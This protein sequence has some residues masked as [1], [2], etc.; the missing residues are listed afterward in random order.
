M[1]RCLGAILIFFISLSALPGC[2]IKTTN[3]APMIAS[4]LL[5]T[6]AL[7][8][9]GAEN[10]RPIFRPGIYTFCGEKGRLCEAQKP[11]SPYYYF[12]FR[13]NG[14]GHYIFNGESEPLFTF[15]WSVQGPSAKLITH[16]NHLVPA[17]LEAV[18]TYHRPGVY[19]IKQPKHYYFVYDQVL[20]KKQPSAQ[21]L[22][23][24]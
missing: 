19:V 6:G 16:G 8:Y 18:F 23:Q 24:R 11:G 10:P 4:D 22:S 2:A 14:T 1:S 7:Y 13:P 21:P 20:N 17:S 15:N 5:V 9:V 12:E 3:L